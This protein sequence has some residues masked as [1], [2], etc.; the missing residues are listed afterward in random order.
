MRTGTVS[1]IA[2]DLINFELRYYDESRRYELLTNLVSAE[3]YQSGKTVEFTTT[4]GP[5][6]DTL[7][8]ICRLDDL[9]FKITWKF[10]EDLR[11]AVYKGFRRGGVTFSES[12]DNL[13]NST[14][15]SS[16]RDY[17]NIA[18]V[19]D[20]DHRTMRVIADRGNTITRNGFE[21][22]V[23][24][25]HASGVDSSEEGMTWDKVTPLLREVAVKELR[26]HDPLDAFD[27][28]VVGSQ[29]VYGEHYEMGDIVNL[30]DEHIS[31]RQ[32]RVTE[33]IWSLDDNGLSQ[34]PTFTTL[35]E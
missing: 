14:Y 8:D 35:P 26:K 4:P 29:F 19:W 15:V 17:A 10:G 24:Y 28:Q 31:N 1:K 7:Q 32:A 25:V 27:G 18:H 33:Y 30:F 20:R 9:G 16:T 13:K 23:I 11:F 12:L 34:Y 2:I 5:L 6:Y 3:E 21:R 22:R